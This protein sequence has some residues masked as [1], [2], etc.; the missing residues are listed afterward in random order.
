MAAPSVFDRLG[1]LS[2]PTRSRLL[3]VLDRHELTVSELCAVVQ[4]PQSTVSRH[5]K[6]LADEGWVTS[7]AEGT[8]R[9]YTIAGP[10]E[11]GARRLWQVVREEVSGGSTATHDAERVRAVLAERRTRA[12]EFFSTAAGQWDALRGELFGERADLHAL[13]ALLDDGW[14]VGDLGCG[15]GRLSA[16]LAP[17]VGRVVAVDSSRAMLA[18]ARKRLADA[19]NVELRAGDLESLP[20]K[21]GELDAAVLALV[22]HYAGDPAA[23]LAEAR[24]ALK[25]GG[26]L[27]V[28]DTMPHEREEYRRQMGH[29]WLG[30]SEPQMAALLADAGLERAR[31][32][33]LPI[34]PNARGPQLFVATARSGEWRVASGERKARKAESSPT[35]ERSPRDREASHAAARHSP[36]A[37]RH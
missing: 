4:L 28:I 3:H 6:I 17:F 9:L 37:T 19:P 33:P 29:V 8:S 13:L 15:T 14:T 27:L 2:D 18:A 16:A 34:D 5:L 32:V 30:F 25:P 31:Y 23:A 22:L 26:R 36:L 10:L 7:R 24:R 11:P 20:V 1:T 35:K 21:D 12:Q